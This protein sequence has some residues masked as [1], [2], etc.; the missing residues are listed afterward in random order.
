MGNAIDRIKD[1]IVDSSKQLIR[2]RLAKHMEFV[3]D[4]LKTKRMFKY[5]NVNYGFPVM[6]AQEKEL[7]INDPVNITMPDTRMFEVN[8]SDKPQPEFR[9]NWPAE[10]KEHNLYSVC[11]GCL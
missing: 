4:R 5:E 3:V 2:K 8:Y 7:I 9:K 11:S 6:T 1:V 10:L